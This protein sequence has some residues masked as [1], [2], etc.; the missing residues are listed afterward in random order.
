VATSSRAIAITF[1]MVISKVIPK[2]SWLDR[3]LRERLA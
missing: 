2:A 3:Q 1:F